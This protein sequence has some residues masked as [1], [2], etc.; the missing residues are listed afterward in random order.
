MAV[1][2]LTTRVMAT[3][4][5]DWKK[6]VHM[7]RYLHGTK[8]LLLTLH[9]DGTNIV[10]WWVDGLHAVHPDCKGHTGAIQLMG[11]GAIVNSFIKKKLN[12]RSSTETEVVAAD[13]VM[14]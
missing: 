9:A 13:G 11:T 7:M 6:L 4:E 1:A 5:D 2:F 14:P 10:K 12:N 3:D 8:D